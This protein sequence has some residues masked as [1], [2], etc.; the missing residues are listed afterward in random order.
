M[1]Q[2]AKSSNFSQSLL[3][4]GAAISIAEILTGALI[5]PLG[6]Q[7]GLI[8]I[9]L[10]H[11]IGCTILYLSGLIGAKTKLSAIES[12]RISFGK[13]GSYVFSIINIIQLVGWSAVMIINGA[14]A[15][16]VVTKT[17]L[18]ITNV[19]LWC[20]LIAVL[21]CIWILIGFKNLNKINIVAVGGLLI[22]TLIL[23]VHVFLSGSTHG[24]EFIGNISFGG[25]V[26]LSVIMPLSWLPLISDYT[27]NVKHEKMGTLSSA[28]GYFVGSTFMYSIGLGAAILTGTSDISAILILGGL[29]F[30][31]LIVVLLSTVTTT[32]LD[33][34]SAAVSFINLTNKWNEKLISVI[35]CIVGLIIA[36][37]I[38]SS[39]YENF[40]YLIGS[41]FAPLFAILLTD[42]F[43]LKNNKLDE[44]NMINIKNLII[45]VIGVLIYR[46]F[47]NLDT[48]IGSTLPTMIILSILYIIIDG[49][50]K[51]CSK[52]F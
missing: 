13:Y 49:G 35:V 2:T 38:P 7:K 5:T 18:H 47:M 17:S 23:T 26:E 15:F 39:H 42:F 46:L 20:V 8:A 21:L 37:L 19:I 1:E 4:F 16:D 43:I 25:A 9:I 30:V 40:L 44:N 51:L 14:K 48:P 33:V 32:F 29:S 36:I 24:T 52:K 34:Y 45:W 41:A 31:A 50:I 6:L 27:K 11:I 12:T 22:F 10:G 3:W 28:G